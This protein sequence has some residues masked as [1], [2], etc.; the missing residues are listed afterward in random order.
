MA[1]KLVIVESPAK[2]K[3]IS[4]FLGR[5]YKVE[6]S[7]GHVRD[8]PKSQLGVDIENDFEPKY[9]T[10]RGRGDILARIRKEA[11]NAAK[12]YL[13][14]DPDREG[15]AISWQLASILGIDPNNACRIDFHEVTNKAVKAA[16]KKPRAINTS[17]VDA[18]QARRVLDRLVGYTI[19]PLLWAKVKKGLS[20]GRV[21]SVAAKLICDREEE[22]DSF[23]PE[24]YWTLDADF[25][26][27]GTTINAHFT[28]FDGEKYEPASREQAEEA[29]EKSRRQGYSVTAVKK[30]ERRKFAAPPFTTSNLQ[31]EAS[32]KLNFTTQKTM[33]IA[34]Q[35][36]EGVE[37]Q[38]A[39]S[40]GLVTYIRTDSTRSSAEAVAAVRAL[41]FENYGADYLPEQPNTFRTRRSAQ[42][43]HEAIRPTFLE[44]APGRIKASLSRD[45]YKLY[46]LIYDR[47]VASQMSP[48]AY[49]T[50]SVDITGT[51]GANYHFNAQKLQ[52]AGFT[53]VYEESQDD[54]QEEQNAR[55]LPE[56]VQGQQANLKGIDPEQ[57]FTQP[58]PRYTEA[59][60]VRTLEEKGIGRP[61]TYAPTI[62]TI[63]NRGY[64]TREKKRLIPTELGKIVNDMMC[65]NF[66]DIVDVEF[67]ARMEDELD[68]VEQGTLDWH[69]VIREFYGPFETSLQKAE[70][71]IEKVEIEDQVSDIPCEKCGSMMV[72]KMGRFGKFLACPNFPACRNT[73]ALPSTIGVK[74]PLC[75][76][77]L[78]ERV[79]RKGRKFYGCERYPE[80][81]FV[82]WDRP[83]SDLCPVCGGHMVYKRGSKGVAYHLCVNETCRHK[84]EIE[85]ANTDEQ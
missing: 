70:E 78:L 79:S 15:E 12:I 55:S 54:A 65:R 1:D 24:E 38:G 57:H 74:C 21:Q 13:A 31:Q 9:I 33:Q 49:D 59:S 69:S 4:K 66:P 5:T 53:A 46:K 28:G 81:I 72:Y 68:A 8:L 39:G 85:A 20:A 27:D 64:V 67:T 75:G 26:I 34:Q 6:A 73:M 2:A 61:S 52:F 71:S 16:V 42:D 40:Q 37:I 76:G 41:I 83:V 43:A 19:S 48:A 7:Q 23:I 3:T 11:K 62:S 35:L 56:F 32:R 50:L 58:P 63:I 51:D 77:E 17:L 25:D 82:S 45:Q 36:Y 10:I 22:I 18:Q 47:F 14:T 30:G 80:C 84:V 60:L 44:Y 29:M